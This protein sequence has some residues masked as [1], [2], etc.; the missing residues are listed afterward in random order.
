MGTTSGTGWPEETWLTRM[1]GRL[2]ADDGQAA[3]LDDTSADVIPM[4]GRGHGRRGDT[5]PMYLGPVQPPMMASTQPAVAY[6]AY[7][8]CQVSA[9]AE[10]QQ[11]SDQAWRA[12]QQAMR[13]A[14]RAYESVMAFAGQQLDTWVLHS[15]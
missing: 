6:E 1:R 13:E 5:T 15:A 10:Y 7:S 9:W 11:A 4:G 2:Q 12:Y 8:R 14:E 3:E